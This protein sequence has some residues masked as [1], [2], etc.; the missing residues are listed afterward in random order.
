MRTLIADMTA[1]VPSARPTIDQVV[2]RFDELRASLNAK[3][4]R[5]RVV[6]I[7]DDLAVRSLPSMPRWTS[8]VESIV[9]GVSSATQG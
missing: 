5:A 6:G 4:L 1:V 7:Y 2:Q 9:R 3:Q 8:H